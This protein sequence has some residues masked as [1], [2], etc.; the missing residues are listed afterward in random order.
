MFKAMIA[1]PQSPAGSES[2]GIDVMKNSSKNTIHHAI[3][4]NPGRAPGAAGFTLFELLTV[5]AILSILL[6]LTI[7]VL[8][9]ARKTAKIVANQT[10]MREV[11]VGTQQFR[12]DNAEQSASYFTA[13][14]LGS[15]EN[16]SR[17]FSPMQSILLNLMGG[18]A[19]SDSLA[20]GT[21]VFNNV[22]PMVAGSVSVNPSKLAAG[23][24]SQRPGKG[25]YLTIPGNNLKTLYSGDADDF[26]TGGNLLVA[27]P[28]GPAYENHSKIPEL[29]DAFGTPILAWIEDER[30][31]PED[32]TALYAAQNSDNETARFYYASNAMY[33]NSPTNYNSW[34]AAATTPNPDQ[35]LSVLGVVTGSP[36]FAQSPTQQAGFNMPRASRSGIILH[37]AGPDGVWVAKGNAGPS[38]A[39][40]SFPASSNGSDPMSDFDDTVVGV[41][42]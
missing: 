1:R 17:G 13:K 16:I 35:R 8:G 15:G 33:L 14:Q 37:S 22:G 10:L 26:P 23:E 2:A 36:A 20:A 42:N 11:A 5:L 41:G 25:A 29:I 38:A 27:S 34:L 6:G 19:A 30:I 18:V 12:L 28:M 31:R 24:S 3:T 32:S 40:P 4:R 7:P 9:R 21:S 39:V